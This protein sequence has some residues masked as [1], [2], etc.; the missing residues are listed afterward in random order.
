MKNK[1][2]DE[3]AGA[4]RGEMVL[5]QAAGGEIEVEVRLEKDTLWLSL[6]QLSELFDRDKS[7]ISRHL[8]NVFDEG[9]LDRSAAVA[10]NATVQTE[11]DREVTRNVEYYN[12]DAIISVGYRVNSKRGTQFRIPG[13]AAG[14]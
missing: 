8:R 10:K 1:K 13:A 2:I 9:E 6:N 3:E 5:Y 14:H 11:G 12:L 7:V 4:S